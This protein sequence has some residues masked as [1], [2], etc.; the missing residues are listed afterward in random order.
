MN[1]VVSDSALLGGGHEP[2]VV[3]DATGAGHGT[4]PAAV[5]RNLTASALDHDATWL[6]T[7]YASTR[8]DLTGTTSRRRFFVDGLADLLRIRDQGIC[9]SPWCDARCGSSTTSA[10]D[11]RR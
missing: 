8:G 5:A 1:L 6:R 10:R 7:V 2:A 4:I 9:R 3:L 11:R